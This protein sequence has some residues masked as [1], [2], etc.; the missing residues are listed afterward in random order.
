MLK[1][2]DNMNAIRMK[3]YRLVELE[4]KKNLKYLQ[5]VHVTRSIEVSVLSKNHLSFGTHHVWIRDKN[6]KKKLRIFFG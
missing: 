1:N 4:M 5:K 2:V 3:F 6:A